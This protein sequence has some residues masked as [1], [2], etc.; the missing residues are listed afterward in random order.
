MA[1]VMLEDR[2][3]RSHGSGGAI[4]PV[5]RIERRI[6]LIRDQKV[7]LGHD[8]AEL[9][10]VE[11]KQLN[12]AVRRNIDRFPGDFMF[13]LT[14][15]VTAD[16]RRQSGTSSGHGGPPVPPAGVHRTRRGD[17]V[18]RPAI[19]ARDIIRV[20]VRLRQLLAS[21]ADLRRKLDELQTRYDHQFAVV[22]DALRDL[23]ADDQ[24][25]RC[26]P[27]IG[28]QTEHKRRR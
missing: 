19:S 10:Q 22:F 8:L 11:T 4:V 15:E 28:F 7:M 27:P 21:H 5:E 13:E 2:R 20:F 16:L 25:H 26:K 23:M 12:R 18:G 3:G 6:Y 14:A 1:K 24:R 9:Y 17:A